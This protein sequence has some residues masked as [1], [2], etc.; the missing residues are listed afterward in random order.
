MVSDS[1]QDIFREFV[2]SRFMIR[3]VRAEL[4]T[5]VSLIGITDDIELSHT[6]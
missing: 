5:F 1:G 4:K 3:F 2:I 6:F